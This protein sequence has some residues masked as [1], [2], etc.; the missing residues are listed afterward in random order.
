MG[1]IT[2]P[3]AKR[4]RCSGIKVGRHQ[5]EA[6][7]DPPKVVAQAGQRKQ[8]GQKPVYSGIVEN[9]SGNSARQTLKGSKEVLTKGI[10]EVL[11]QGREQQDRHCCAAPRKLVK[12]RLEQ[13]RRFER[14]LCG[15]A[16]DE[17]PVQVGGAQAISQ[18][19]RNKAA[20]TDANIGVKVGEIEAIERLR[21]RHHGANL[22]DRAERTPASQRQGRFRLTGA[23]TH[24]SAPRRQASGP[25]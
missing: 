10:A 20:R 15:I 24:I 17:H 21:K 7:P 14:N 6:P 8:A 19:G 22:I 1:A 4:D 5:K 3:G 18:A 12:R 13:H 11:V 2:T 25:L 16:V 9:A 23:Q